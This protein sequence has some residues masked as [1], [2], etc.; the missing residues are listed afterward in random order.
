[1]PFFYESTVSHAG[2]TCEQCVAGV[3]CD[4]PGSTLATLN[5]KPGYWRFSA[6]AS[7]VYRCPGHEESCLGGTDPSHYCAPWLGGIYCTQC[8]TTDSSRHYDQGS[9]ECLPCEEVRPSAAAWLLLLLLLGFS[10]GSVLVI[11]WARFGKEASHPLRAC[12]VATDQGWSQPT[13][14]STHEGMHEYGNICIPFPQ[15]EAQ[16]Q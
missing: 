16:E 10:G 3:D 12:P 6:S 1:M 8:N 11:V 14:M 5:L 4:T 7:D 2:P 13:L 9:R 15:R